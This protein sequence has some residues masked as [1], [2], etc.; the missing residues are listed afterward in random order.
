MQ[1]V[2]NLITIILLSISLMFIGCA[3]YDLNSSGDAYDHNPIYWPLALG[4]TSTS[5]VILLGLI[6][7]Y[8]MPDDLMNEMQ[9]IKQYKI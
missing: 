5:S 7:K 1:V 9:T 2:I 3:F 8:L 4:F 6:F